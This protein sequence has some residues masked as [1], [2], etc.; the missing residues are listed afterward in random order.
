MTIDRRVLRFVPLNPV[1]QSKVEQAKLEYEL[2]LIREQLK[3]DKPIGM[4]KKGELNRRRLE[5]LRLLSPKE[6][7][8]Q[9]SVVA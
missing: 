3:S 9:V 1:G 4:A 8:E 6:Q 2:G 7:P 5:I